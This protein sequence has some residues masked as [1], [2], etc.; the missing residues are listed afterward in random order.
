VL[1]VAYAVIP[2]VRGIAR[3]DD[4][5]S[6]AAFWIVLSGILGMMTSFAL[7]GTVEVYIYRILG[8]DWFAAEV[9]PAM[10][11]WRGMLFVFGSLFAVGVV[12][13]AYDLFTIKPRAGASPP[14]AAQHERERRAWWRNPLSSLEM[15]GWLATLV[16]LGLMLTFGLFSNNLITVR[17]GD[18]TIPYTVAA[19]GYPLLAIVTLLFALRFLRACEA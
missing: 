6:R 14:T 16:F 7:G 13:L 11:F 17:L 9:R 8:L 4:R 1:G 18:P 12:A 5:V 10:Q 2:A 15:S 3:P 19:I